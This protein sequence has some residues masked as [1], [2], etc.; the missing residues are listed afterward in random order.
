MTTT[1]LALPGIAF[2]AGTTVSNSTIPSIITNVLAPF[3][4]GL[5]PIFVA[6]AL[7]GFFWGAA[8]FIW[9]AGDEK[10]RAEGRYVMIWGVIA[11]FFFLSIT[12]II[13]LLQT[14]LGVGGNSVITPPSAKPGDYGL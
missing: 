4:N 14:E 2:A 6:L 11:L 7:L 13:N 3:F 12:G 9:N 1:V 5:I 10:K 8:T